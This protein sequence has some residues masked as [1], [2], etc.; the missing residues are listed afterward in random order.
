M[1]LGDIPG[2]GRGAYALRDIPEEHT[3]FTVPRHIILSPRTSSLPGLLGEEAW[4]QFNLGKRWAGLILCMMWEEAQGESS[5]WSGYLAD[6][7]STFDTPMFWTSEDLEELK[8]TALVEDKVGRDQAES[9]YREQLMPAALSR[10]DL[11]PSEKLLQYYTLERYHVMGSRILSRSFTVQEWEGSEDEDAMAA[12]ADTSIG[13]G[14]DVDMDANTPEHLEPDEVH[15]QDGTASDDGSDSGDEEDTAMVPIA[16]MLNARF[17]HENVKIFYEK[18]ALSMITTKPIKP[19]EQIVGNSHCALSVYVTNQSF[20]SQWNTYGDPPNSDLLHVVELLASIV[21]EAVES[22][23]KAVGDV[24]ERVDWWLD[25]V[26]YDIF[27]IQSDCEVHELIT[28]VILLIMPVP[29]WEKTQKKGKLPKP[30]LKQEI[31]PILNL[32]IE[33]RLAQYPTS[34]PEDEMLLQT[35]LSENKRK[36]TVVR[37]GE[38]Y[39]LVAAMAKLRVLESLLQEDALRVSKKRKLD[40]GAQGNGAKKTKT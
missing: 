5:K 8:G 34:I 6:L 24:Q 10:P 37:L 39:I 2:C 21:V 7:P 15:E 13:S 32:A 20:Y 28:F 11:F 35:P 18:R 27:V 16:D 25:R 12:D 29:E 33:K 14:M 22:S 9:A 36:A 40:G 30:R 31:V 4:K 3:L 38:K 1:G 19:G 26:D 23:G 17:E